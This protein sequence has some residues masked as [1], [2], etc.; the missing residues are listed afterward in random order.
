MNEASQAGSLDAAARE[1]EKELSPGGFQIKS[2]SDGRELVWRTVKG[3]EKRMLLPIEVIYEEDLEGTE[4]LLKSISREEIGNEQFS[5]MVNA[6]KQIQTQLKQSSGPPTSEVSLEEE[7]VGASDAQ[8]NTK[9]SSYF[10]R[11]A[12]KKG[13]VVTVRRTLKG[14]KGKRTE[15]LR[16]NQSEL[17]QQISALVVGTDSNLDVSST[18][19]GKEVLDAAT[20]FE[21]MKQKF[22][23]QET[24]LNNEEQLQELIKAERNEIQRRERE[25]A[26]LKAQKEEEERQKRI[27]GPGG[28]YGK[29]PGIA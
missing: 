22:F 7:R 29:S 5:K 1:E 27:Y 9:G 26:E 2:R 11:A 8:S 28:A 18:E 14:K 15:T 23:Q 25:A 21:Q 12:D 16:R 24:R 10:A 13:A 4:K 3:V 6:M 17:N 20:L 19:N